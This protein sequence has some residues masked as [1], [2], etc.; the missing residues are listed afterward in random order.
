MLYDP[1]MWT[2]FA[3]PWS[4]QNLLFPPFFFTMLLGTPIRNV[5]QDLTLIRFVIAEKFMFSCS[6]RPPRGR[7]FRCV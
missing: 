3:E 2:G 7:I 1:T 6:L 4:D 5:Y